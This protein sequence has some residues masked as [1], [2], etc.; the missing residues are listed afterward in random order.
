MEDGEE[1]LSRRMA[2]IIERRVYGHVVIGDKEIELVNQ[3]TQTIENVDGN[4]RD[5]WKKV[6]SIVKHS[7]GDRNNISG[8]THP[9]DHPDILK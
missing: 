3:I 7:K 5:N 2:K 4:A 9:K 8:K 1:T 6:I